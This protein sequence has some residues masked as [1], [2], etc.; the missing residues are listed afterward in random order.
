MRR[1]AVAAL[2]FATVGAS[3]LGQ[4]CSHGR[5]ALRV[6]GSIR[7]LALCFEI[8]CPLEGQRMGKWAGNTDMGESA[9]CSNMGRA[10]VRKGGVRWTK[11]GRRYRPS[12]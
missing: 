7:R 2:D 3:V 4:L 9:P 5:H 12:P 6:E 10:H 1:Q 8:V 11:S